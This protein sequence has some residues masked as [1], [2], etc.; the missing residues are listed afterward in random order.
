MNTILQFD[1]SYYAVFTAGLL[2]YIFAGFAKFGSGR[3]YNNHDPRAFLEQAEGQ[4]RRANNAQ[5]NSFEAFPFFAV[6]VLVAHQ[7]LPTNA[8]FFTLNL[9]CLFFLIFRLAY[10][11]A[12]ISNRANLR[13]ILWFIAIALAGSLYF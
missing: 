10:G 3:P 7:N 2:P 6:G 12:Y 1:L 11:W 9:I 13:S 8:S 5:L 4:Y